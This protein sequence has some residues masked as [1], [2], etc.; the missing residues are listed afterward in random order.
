MRFFIF[1]ITL[2]LIS[3]SV[4]AKSIDQKKKELKKVYESGGITKTEY[5][6]AMEFLEKPKKNK[7]SQNEK[8]HNYIWVL[9]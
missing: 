6:K 3:L 2:T 5:I 1:L 8:N 7:N 4:S 9:L